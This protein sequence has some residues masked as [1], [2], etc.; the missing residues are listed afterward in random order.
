MISLDLL[1]YWNEQEGEPLDPNEDLDLLLHTANLVDHTFYGVDYVRAHP[2]HPTLCVISSFGFEYLAHAT[3]SN[4]R[5][6]MN[7]KLYLYPN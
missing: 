7:R 4:V 5:Q 6:S 3:L 2:D 1:I